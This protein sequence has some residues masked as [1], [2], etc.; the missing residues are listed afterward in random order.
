MVDQP[1]KDNDTNAH[2][3]GTQKASRN[4]TGTLKDRIVE[5]ENEL[6]LAKATPKQ[7][8]QEPSD[9]IERARALVA[10]VMQCHRVNHPHMGRHLQS[11]S[12]VLNE[13]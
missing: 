9:V 1:R 8:Q 11:L 4:Q 12:D 7:A 10:T 3:A 13:E 6:L 5:L 2:D